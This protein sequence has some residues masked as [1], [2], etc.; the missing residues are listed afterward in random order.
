MTDPG[1]DRTALLLARLADTF[2]D[3]PAPLPSIVGAAH[4][5][6]RRRRRRD[7]L[8][9]VAVLALGF[10]GGLAFEQLRPGGGAERS[11]DRI[12]GT[13][14]ACDKGNPVPP[15]EP[16]PPG[17][18]YPTNAAGQTFGSAIDNSPQPDL[19][20]AIGDCGRTG[21]IASDRFAEPA[22]W[23]PGAGSSQPQSVPVYESDGV[24]QIDT[25]TQETGTPVAE[26]VTN[27]PEPTDGPDSDDLLGTWTVQIAGISA[28]GSEQYDTYRDL[29]LWIAFYR[30]GVVQVHNGCRDLGGGFSLESGSFAATDFNLEYGGAQECAREA[31]LTAILNNV[32][33]VTQSRGRAYLHLENF[34]IGLNLT[35]AS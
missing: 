4:A 15:S 1:P 35:R 16:I 23:I 6:R 17:P 26:G 3:Q 2:P 12:A 33:H 19:I 8:L 11:V 21:Y 18:D 28:G 22:P 7:A 10:S 5:E 14:R 25:F 31:P 30:G 9:V 24:T 34:R 32:R 13:A 20:A 29:D 27:P